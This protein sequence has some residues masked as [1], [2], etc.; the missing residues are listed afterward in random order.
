MIWIAAI[1]LVSLGLHHIFMGNV[2]SVP[3]TQ[4]ESKRDID[5]LMCEDH[6]QYISVENVTFVPRTE[7][8]YMFFKETEDLKCNHT[9]LKVTYVLN[10]V[11][12]KTSIGCFCE[13]P[14]VDYCL[15]YNINKGMNIIQ[16]K[17]NA[18]CKDLSLTP[19]K[20]KYNSSESYKL[21][22]C[23]EKYG[24]ISSPIQNQRHIN[25][26]NTEIQELKKIANDLQKEN[27]DLKIYKWIAIV[28]IITFILSVLFIVFTFFHFR[29]I[30]LQKE[31]LQ[32]RTMSLIRTDKG[33]QATMSERKSDDQHKEENR[34]HSNREEREKAVIKSI[35]YQS[36]YVQPED[37]NDDDDEIEGMHDEIPLKPKHKTSAVFLDTETH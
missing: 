8:E 19:C 33:D 22:G 36:E 6:M 1:P 27:D 11:G 32:T 15:E 5:N 4:K 35:S 26:L 20:V 7:E 14:V 2:T 31:S 13:K 34:D 29:K 18:L 30:I 28:F 17:L 10:P 9:M 16:S 37:D 21:F 24:G 12:N 25:A 23:F 3:M